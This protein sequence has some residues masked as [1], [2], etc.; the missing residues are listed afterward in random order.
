MPLYILSRRIESVRHRDCW[1][2]LETAGDCWRLLETAAA[3]AAAAA[4]TAAA[5]A[6][7]TMAV[8]AGRV[9]GSGRPPTTTNLQF[10]MDTYY[11]RAMRICFVRWRVQGHILT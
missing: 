6:A 11:M 8:A 4:T 2:L 9:S 10:V 1:R 3:A 7:V 5:A